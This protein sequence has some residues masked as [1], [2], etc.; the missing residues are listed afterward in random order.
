MKKFLLSL[1]ILLALAATAAA[2]TKISALPSATPITTDIVPFV[3]DPAGTAVTKKTTIANLLSVQHNHSASDITSGLLPDS[4]ISSAPTWNAKES[5]LTFNLPFTRSGNSISLADT[6]VTPGSYTNA[7]ITVDQ[8]GRITAAS[9]GSYTWTQIDKTTSSL[10][11]LTT[12]SASDLSSGTLPDARFPATLPVS[13]GA[14]LTSLNGSNITSGTVAASRLGTMTGADGVS[15]GAKGAVPAPAATDN[16]K[17]LRGDGTY[18]VPTDTNSGGT[19]TSVGLSTPGV[20][21]SVS[22]SPVTT[23][24]TLALNLITQSANC[25]F[26]GPTTGGPATPSCRALVVADLPTSIPNANLANSSVTINTTSPLAGGG[27]VSL[28]GT[29]SLTTS[30]ASSVT[31]DT[32]VTGSISGNVLTLGWAGSLAKARTLG[33]TVYTDQVNTFG[34]FAQTFQ[35]GTNFN[36]VDPTDTSKKLQFA[37]SG[38]STATTITA[39]PPTTSFQIARIDAGQTFQGNEVFTGNLR[40]AGANAMYAGNSGGTYVYGV[41]NTGVFSWNSN[42]DASGRETGVGRGTTLVVEYNNGTQGGAGGTFR[43]IPTS[44]ASITASQNDYNPGGSSL[45]QRWATSASWNITGLT[46]SSAQISG[47]THYIVNVGSFSIVL[48]NE[49]TSSTAANRFRNT[50]G[51]DITLSADQ[52]AMCWYDG[53]NSRWRCS[54]MN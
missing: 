43:S 8:K 37:L 11:D 51:A 40:I 50:T 32:N 47:Q 25:M 38:L 20:F 29:L 14:N 1:G 15:A 33:T 27:S 3:S 52:E 42:S 21:Y 2:Q 48:V 39:T 17:F 22:G 6:A 9:S 45:Y 35:A 41:G 36:L 5:L 54:K 53:V 26:A 24:G 16:L 4:R 23:T 10:G 49:S 19:V 46:F 44:P 7:S 31:N 13:S 30:A 12:R 18:A 28:G 34:N